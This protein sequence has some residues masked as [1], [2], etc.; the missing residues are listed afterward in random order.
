MATNT[1]R[2]RLEPD[3]FKGKPGR[4]VGSMN[5]LAAAA[6]EAASR[7]GALPHELLLQW[8]RGEPMSRKVPPVDATDEQLRDVSTWETEYLAVEPDT[9]K[10]CANAAAPYFAPKI[11]TV[12]VISGVSDADL[13]EFIARAAAEAGL[14]VGAGG[15]GTEDPRTPGSDEDS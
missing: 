5:R 12:E 13:D 14:S 2:V 11:S 15:E 1:R 7:T 9:M 8:G 4:P 6:R 10:Y 3:D